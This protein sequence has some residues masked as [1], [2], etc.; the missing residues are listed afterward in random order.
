VFNKQQLCDIEG[1]LDKVEASIRSDGTASLQAA[2][3]L[4]E[5]SQ[6]NLQDQ[7][8]DLVERIGRLTLGV[9][10]GI[11]KVERKERRIDAVIGRARKELKGHGLESPALD[12][13]NHELRLID[14]AGSEEQGMPTVPKEV[15]EPAEQASS[16]R[17]VSLATLQRARGIR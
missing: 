13:E 6:H 14:G 4:L 2:L 11:E 3:D 17:G 12:S 15:A 8:S 7:T 10:E 5:T 9:A 16:V 1:R